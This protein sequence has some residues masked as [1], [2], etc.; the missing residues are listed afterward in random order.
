MNDVTPFFTDLG[1]TSKPNVRLTVSLTCGISAIAVVLGLIG[2]KASLTLLAGI[3]AAAWST[4]I[5]WRNPHWAGYAL[6]IGFPLTEGLPRVTSLA[7][8][9]PSE[10]LVL[11][12]L[13]QL[14]IHTVIRRDPLPHLGWIDYGALMLVASGTI[15]PLVTHIARGGSLSG[16]DISSILW[17]VKDYAI[18]WVIRLAVRSVEQA[19]RIVMWALI[20]SVVVALIGILQGMGVRYVE[21]F[22][23][24]YYPS[25][26]VLQAGH[27]SRVTSV[28]VGWNDL[29]AYL[30]FVLLVVGALTLSGNR[31]LPTPML[32]VAIAVD[33]VALLI[34]GSITS[35]V[36]LVG[37]IIVAAVA[38]GQLTQL[39]K[40]MV[41]AIA[42]IVV[43]GVAFSPLII[44]RLEYQYNAG[45]SGIIPQSFLY[46]IFLWKTY[47]LPLIAQHPILGVGLTI[48]IT[49][50]WTT[51]DSG[52]LG[53]LFYG[54]VI[55]LL[56][57]LFFTW[58][59]LY[60]TRRMAISHN[61]DY[62]ESRTTSVFVRGLAVASMSIIVILL[63]MN[64]T[65]AYYTYGAAVSILWT[66]LALATTPWEINSSARHLLAAA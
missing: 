20:C 36:A 12:L 11:F 39:R 15:L 64:V 14:V 16:Q 41:P 18:Y 42:A 29:G 23:T 8:L 46:R 48:P 56:G 32:F 27:F 28:L 7:G 38:A 25:I 26:Q 60:H 10:A 34:T 17:P 58:T 45:S 63:F 54:G 9:R 37:G 61:S 49:I 57:Y 47:F 43:A 22:L 30:A 2:G 50:P 35:L 33:V 65:D 13:G 6:A 62:A 19:R 66:T 3:V 4:A 55:S 5:I 44:G 21:T 52:Y 40:V 59:V 53:L 31:I 24:A 1:L 51:T